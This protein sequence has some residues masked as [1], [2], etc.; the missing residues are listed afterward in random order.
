MTKKSPPKPLPMPSGGGSYVRKSDGTL[1][2]AAPAE[3]PETTQPK[4][5]ENGA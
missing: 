5:A 4:D 2:E 1:T 3:A